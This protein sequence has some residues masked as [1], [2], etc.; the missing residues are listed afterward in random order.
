M[1]WLL[2]ACA[3]ARRS[4][5]IAGPMTVEPEG[6]RVFDRHCYSCHP[7][8][9]G[10]L[11][12]TLNNRPLPGFLVR[13]QVRLGLGAMP[14]HDRHHLSDEELDALVRYVRALRRH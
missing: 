12:P 8:G 7:G 4:E 2:L 1:I 13:W 14:P 11:G 3:S 9:E 10:G 5:P 6:E